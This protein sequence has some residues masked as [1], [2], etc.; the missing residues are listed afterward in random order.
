MVT[1]YWSK[2]INRTVKLL[3]SVAGDNLVVKNIKEIIQ[4]LVFAPYAYW[5]IRVYGA[6]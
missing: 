1:F 3:A 4:N 2:H 6:V 5:S